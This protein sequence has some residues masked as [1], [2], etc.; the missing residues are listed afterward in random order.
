MKV[1]WTYEA[2]ESFNRI[3]DYL[4]ARWTS[5]EANAF[6]DLVAEIIEHIK[7]FPEMYKISEYD[8]Q[9]R[10]ALITKHT[11]MFY[12]ISEGK[13]EIEY[14]WGNLQDPQRLKN[15]LEK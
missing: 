5:K 12:R 14:F 4:L 2:E 3:I 11:T 9:S 7:S 10:E 15:I 13:I 8:N 6:I 1:V